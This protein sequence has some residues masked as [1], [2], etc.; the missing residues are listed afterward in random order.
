MTAWD[1]ADAKE[2]SWPQ[3]SALVGC[4]SGT[5]GG[6]SIAV[7]M[8]MSSSYLGCNSPGY[9]KFL[10]KPTSQW[11][12]GHRA[13][14][15]EFKHHFQNMLGTS[16]IC[17]S[18]MLTPSTAQHCGP[19]WAGAQRNIFKSMLNVMKMQA[20]P[21]GMLNSATNLF[22]NLIPYSHSAIK[23]SVYLCARRMSVF[24]QCWLCTRA[25][26]LGCLIIYVLKIRGDVWESSYCCQQDIK[27]PSKRAG[28]IAASSYSIHEAHQGAFALEV[29][30][31][32]WS[33][34]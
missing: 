7:P 19:H 4:S 2:E 29:L 6:W 5:A 31:E 23:F 1:G 21:V 32:I 15:S 18:L 11:G 33:L 25:T 26:S 9:L 3:A 8:L 34:N 30:M 24:S 10:M 13:K 22:A 16:A 14:N 20:F 12:R 17:F 27:H 28:L